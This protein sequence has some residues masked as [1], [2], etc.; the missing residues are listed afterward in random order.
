[1]SSTIAWTISFSVHHGAALVR[2]TRALQMSQMSGSM[3]AV[4]LG[5]FIGA[6]LLE[7]GRDDRSDCVDALREQHLGC[8]GVRLNLP[9]RLLQGG[10]LG[11][12]NL[13][14]TG[15]NHHHHG[16]LFEEFDRVI[17]GGGRSPR[18][19]GVRHHTSSA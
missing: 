10:V 13:V 17:K 1:M 9:Q 6:G 15:K 19:G 14:L 2:V 3:P 7:G 4:K 12:E 5:S 16:A 18:G 8:H 11:E